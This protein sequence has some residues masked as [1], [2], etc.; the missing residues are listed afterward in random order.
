MTTD[1]E[2][3]HVV[4]SSLNEQEAAAVMEY[5]NSLGIKS[6]SLGANLTGVWGYGIPRHVIDVVVPT[7]DAERAAAALAGFR[8]QQ[9]DI[10]WDEIDVGD[11][12]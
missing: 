9:S 10:N 11:P 5:L 4:A 8:Q 6:Q 12:E 1:P 3:P 7:A 2:S